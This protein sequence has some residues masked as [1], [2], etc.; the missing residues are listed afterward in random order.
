MQIQERYEPY[1]QRSYKP[2]IMR[3]GNIYRVLHSLQ[4]TFCEYGNAIGHGRY[5]LSIVLIE[6]PEYIRKWKLREV[7]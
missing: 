2:G 7:K 3:I 5:S 4:G 6:C 1:S